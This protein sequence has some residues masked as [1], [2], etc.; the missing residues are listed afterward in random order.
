MKTFRLTSSFFPMAGDQRKNRCLV[1]PFGGLK[2]AP[3]SPI[4]ETGPVF[5]GRTGQRRA[6]TFFPKPHR[7]AK[8]EPPPHRLFL[9]QS[10]STELK[11]PNK[12]AFQLR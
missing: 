10:L 11:P 8:T 4:T 2:R 5:V 9:L 3:F 12:S 1:S 7:L 6:S